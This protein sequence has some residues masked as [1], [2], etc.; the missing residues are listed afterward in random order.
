[1]RWIARLIASIAV[2]IATLTCALGITFLGAETV[3]AATQHDGLPDVHLRPLAQR[4]EIVAADG[5]LLS[6]L[7]E[8]DRQPVSLQAVPKVLVD[9]VVSTEDSAFYEHD[10]VSVR[11]LFRAA[12]ANAT[13]GAVEEGGST[14]TQQL[15]K[16]SILTADRTYDRKAREAVLAFRMEHELTKDQILETYLNTV[17]FGEGAY[18]VRAAATRY[19]GKPLEQVSLPDA[20][21]LA[22]MI[23]SP[24]RFDPVQHA[25]AA[26]VRR[27]HV[28]GR[29][30]KSGAITRSQANEADTAPL[31]TSIVRD[32]PQPS[33][34][35]TEEVR[36]QLL[37]DERLG[38][39]PEERSSLVFRGGIR[40]ET[41]LDPAL[42]AAAEQAVRDKLPESPFTAALVAI[43]PG[44]GDVKALVGGPNF[45]EAK[46]NLATQGARQAG[47]SFKTIALAAW[48]ASG[49]SPEDLVDATA[50]CQ[51]PTPGAPEPFWNVDNYDGEDAPPIVTLREATVHSLNCAYARLALTLGPEKIVD[52]AHKLGLTHDLPVVPSIVLG[53]ATVSPLEMASVYATIAADGVR[54]PPV[55]IRRVLGPDGRVLL[56][57]NPAE[58]RVLEP[59]VAR[60][61][62][63]VLRNVVTRGT[64]R[65]AAIGRP[66]AGKTGTAQEW[67]DA[68]FDGYTPQLAAV[69]WMGSPTGQESMTNVAGIHVTGGSFPAQIWSQFMA[70]AMAPLPVKDFDPVDPTL[71]P[72]NNWIGAPPAVLP[73]GFVLPPHLQPPPPGVIL[74]PA[75]GLPIAPPPPPPPAPTVAPAP[76]PAPAPTTTTTTA[77]PTT[78]TTAKPTTTTTAK[79]PKH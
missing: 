17:Y 43:D 29:M 25:D 8:E 73:P 69:V 71:W 42:Q 41:T 37:A 19:F 61:V 26:L 62:T 47:S 7:Y 16:Q 75:T 5:S 74:D 66:A 53:S 14:I 34:H 39:T 1:M 33:D 23:S 49:R 22:G 65:K 20:A 35:F 2:A 40:V 13:S 76:G 67:R 78:T 63:D 56:A 3:R 44:T 48:I 58:E 77:A 31:P 12:K 60:S 15:V 52:M 57:N 46:Y 11:G 68:W 59:Q 38:A 21:L 55:F 6:A 45:A 30:V 18:G 64:A 72:P 70:A 50:P 36:R 4:S 9:A 24:Q 28:L 79:R 54:R 27:R 10:G 51:F 32:Q